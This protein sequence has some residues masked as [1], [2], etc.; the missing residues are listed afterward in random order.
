LGLGALSGT[1]AEFQNAGRQTV[2]INKMALAVAELRS[3][4]LQ[5]RNQSADADPG[6]FIATV[7]AVKF[8]SDAAALLSNQSPTMAA[9]LKRLEDDSQTYKQVFGQAVEIEKNRQL[10]AEAM[11]TAVVGLR[12]DIDAVSKA[13]ADY[14]ATD[15]V[16]K[17]SAVSNTVLEMLLGERRYLLTSDDT[18]FGDIANHGEE[19]TKLLSSLEGSLFDPSLKKM[20]ASP[21]GH[22]ADYRGLADALHDIVRKRT[23]LYTQLDALGP[24]MEGDLQALNSEVIGH[25]G[26]LELAAQQQGRG[27][28]TIVIAV[29]VAVVL[30]GTLLAVT[31]P[32]TK[33]YGDPPAQRLLGVDL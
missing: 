5:Y 13:A 3:A 4:S 19:A 9:E 18:D 28:M 25:Q 27:T 8:D 11:N 17:L 1:F 30:L 7:A 15:A 12:A 20:L 29:S 14:L 2:E 33:V 31:I 32:T 24:Q 10:T 22:L 21:K 6:R 16:V 26:A 23:T